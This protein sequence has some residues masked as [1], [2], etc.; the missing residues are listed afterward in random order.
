MAQR[1]RD[2]LGEGTLRRDRQRPELPELAHAYHHQFLGGGFDHEE[3]RVAF[4]QAT[5]SASYDRVLHINGREQR[6][7]ALTNPIEYFAEGTEAFFGTDDF[8]PF[9]R[10]EL[11]RH[12]QV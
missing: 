6:A 4:E 2:G 3:L 5:S 10:A 9:V 7:Y 11:E 8:Y 12:D 1:A